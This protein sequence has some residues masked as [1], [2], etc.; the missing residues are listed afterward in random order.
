MADLLQKY[1]EL[2]PL[3]RGRLFKKTKEKEQTSFQKIAKKI[4]KSPAYV[5]NSVRLLRLPP[6][7]QDGLLGGLISEGHAR[8]LI[9]IDDQREC[10]EIYK[11]ILKSHS[12]VREAEELVRQKKKDNKDQLSEIETQNLQKWMEKVFKRSFS[13]IIIKK[14]RNR[15]T[16][17]LQ[18]EPTNL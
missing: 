4:K 10:V 9:S 1:E 7:I 14:T 15:I 5:V 3:D 12:S 16:V 8:A 13:K 17:S 11:I 2:N 18:I 6:A